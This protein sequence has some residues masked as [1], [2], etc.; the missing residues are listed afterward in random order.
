MSGILW[1]S[2]RIRGGAEARNSCSCH[3]VEMR[4]VQ[5][6][7]RKEELEDLRA[8]ITDVEGG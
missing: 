4:M 3:T 1:R 7:F 2:E 6:V 5:G 8:G